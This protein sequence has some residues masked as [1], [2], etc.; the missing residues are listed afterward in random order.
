MGVRREGKVF[1]CKKE[2]G[3]KEMRVFDIGAD[4]GVISVSSVNCCGIC[5]LVKSVVFILKIRVG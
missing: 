5:F 2:F 3:R 4:G 1:L